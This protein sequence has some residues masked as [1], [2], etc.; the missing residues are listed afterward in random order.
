[1]GLEEIQNMNM[2]LQSSKSS[3]YGKTETTQKEETL[4]W[5]RSR[6]HGKGPCLLCSPRVLAMPVFTL[7]VLTWL[8][9]FSCSGLTSTATLMFHNDCMAIWVKNAESPLPELG[10]CLHSLYLPRHPQPIQ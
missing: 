6:R 8:M 5:R 9:R 4:G 2:L 10:Y 3:I 7:D 1:M